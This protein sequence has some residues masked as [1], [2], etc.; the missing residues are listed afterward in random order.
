MLHIKRKRYFIL[1]TLGI[2]LIILY[3]IVSSAPLIIDRTYSGLLILESTNQVKSIDVTI[4]GLYSEGLLRNRITFGGTIRFENDSLEVDLTKFKGDHSANV[5]SS[6]NGK[7]YVL[8]I[9]GKVEEVVLF[10]SKSNN[11]WI[12]V[13]SNSLEEAGDII[14]RLL[15]AE[16][17][18]RH[19]KELHQPVK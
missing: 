8:I 7:E 10:D 18:F 2:I 12:V 4:N 13:P 14:H 9:G 6:M 17:P 1:L 5:V 16:S 15:G 3:G 19:V 11:Q